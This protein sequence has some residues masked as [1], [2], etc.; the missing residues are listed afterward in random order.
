MPSTTITA[1]EP[2]PN[3]CEA[4]GMTAAPHG[5]WIAIELECNHGHASA[6]RLVNSANG[7]TQS[8]AAVLGSNVIFLG[9]SPNG[10]HILVFKDILSEARP[11]LVNVTDGSLLP[12]TTPPNVYNV[13][14]SHDGTKMVYSLTR[15]LGFGSETWLADIDGRNPHLLLQDP[16]H[17]IVYARFS[18]DD[19]KIAYIR[20]MDSNIPFTVG[21]LWVMNSDGSSA[22]KL[23]EADAGHGYA[24]AWSPDSTQ[25]AYVN[26]ENGE[27]VVADQVAE[28]LVSNIR[29][30]N[31]ETTIVKE[32]TNFENTLVESPVWSPD[33][34]QLAF[35]TLPSG[36]GVI[37]VW[38]YEPT[39]PEGAH[40]SA[41]ENA[42]ARYPVFT[43]ER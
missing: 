19:Q 25:I 20:M 6:I 5:P 27:S 31:V 10:Q 1:N 32:V 7:L 35:A 33:G 43:S 15:G 3:N 40:L 29:L 12:L 28:Q 37:D 23:S 41:T 16:T 14:V 18:P 21:E 17:I 42:N 36:G 34:M 39:T 9:W 4:S 8:L 26:R 38:V 22:I 24:P 30:A 13:A 2:I 11:V